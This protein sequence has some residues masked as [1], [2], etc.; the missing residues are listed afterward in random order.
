M[1][2]VLPGGG[3][4][5]GRALPSRAV[6]N[7][8]RRWVLSG[9]IGSGKSEVRRILSDLGVR[10]VDADSVAHVV[11]EPD[12]TAFEAVAARWPEVVTD[13]R[14]DRRA[15]GAI[16][17]ADETQLRELEEFVHPAIFGRIVA[18]VEDFQD[19]VVVEVAILNHRLTGDWGRVVVDAPV[20]MRVSRAVARGLAEEEVRS[21]MAMQPT[22]SEWLA[23]ADLV[24]PNRG[25]IGDLESAVRQAHS[26]ISGT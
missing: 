17:F 7:P 2:P 15:L 11:I 22:R 18:D 19:A 8:Q 20:D 21:R 9:G 1:D 12:G 4:S 14:I 25:S 24:I 10:T 23:A 16:V 6:N 13:G 26:V 5:H 3:G